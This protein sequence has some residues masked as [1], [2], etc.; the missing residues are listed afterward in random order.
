MD[1][2]EVM[3]PKHVTCCRMH[4]LALAEICGLLTLLFC[5]YYAYRFSVS[6][7]ESKGRPVKLNFGPLKLET[8]VIMQTM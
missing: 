4:C 7:Y 5:T 8:G 2:D 1:R 3:L 6:V